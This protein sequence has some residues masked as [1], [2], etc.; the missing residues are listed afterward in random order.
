MK[1]PE[2][3]EMSVEPDDADENDIGVSE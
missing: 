3:D 1:T 2:V